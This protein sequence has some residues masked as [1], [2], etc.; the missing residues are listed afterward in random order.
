MGDNGN[1]Y[2][3][4]GLLSVDDRKLPLR[5]QDTLRLLAGRLHRARKRRGWTQAKM[6]N[7]LFVGLNTYRRMEKGD[8]SV[9]MGAWMQAFD[10]LGMLSEIDGL[11]RYDNDLI[12][13]SMEKDRK[14]KRQDID[15]V[16]DSL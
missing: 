14:R 2:A 9:S 11:L 7:L 12:G 1:N 4:Y 5:T 16:A 13:A 3:I 8:P 6:A 15:A 10:V